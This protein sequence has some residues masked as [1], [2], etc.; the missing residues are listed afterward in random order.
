MIIG[1]WSHGSQAFANDY[2]GTRKTGNPRKAFLYTVRALKGKNPRLGSPFRNARYNLFIMERNEYIGSDTWPPENSEMVPW[3]IG[4]GGYLMPEMY[5]GN[6]QLSYLYDPGDPY[7]GLGG[8]ALGD[9]VGG[10]LQNPNTDR[11][12]QLVFESGILEEPMILLGDITASIWFSSDASCTG[13]VIS[14]Q[15]VFPDGRII[16]IQEGAENVIV[17][18]SGP[19]RIEMP[20]WSTGYQVNPGHSL[21]VVISSGWF[22]RFNRNLNNCEPLYSAENV[23]KANQVVYYGGI[24]PSSINLPLYRLS[25]K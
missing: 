15:D 5:D 19:V 18:G 10:A 9:F 4:P 22:P 25:G 2:G 8:T 13:F 11:P 20:V 6:G 3:Y 23:I 14:V 16:N 7:P 12:D 21:R 24:T 1:P 17:S